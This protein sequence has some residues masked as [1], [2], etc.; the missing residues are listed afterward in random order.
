MDNDPMGN[1]VQD[2]ASVGM[3]TRP[4]TVQEFMGEDLN[5]QFT[6]DLCAE[7]RKGESMT[8]IDMTRIVTGAVLREMRD[9]SGLSLRV[10]AERAGAHASTSPGSSPAN[11]RSPATSVVASPEPSPPAPSR[12][13]RPSATLHTRQQEFGP[14]PTVSTRRHLICLLV[15]NIFMR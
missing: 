4:V 10:M 5:H 6:G 1:P 11:G 7:R 14:M 3:S 12:C 13:A 8:A 15:S 9:A 2:K